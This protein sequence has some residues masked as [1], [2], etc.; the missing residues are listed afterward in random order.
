VLQ[1]IELHS[2]SL[3][4]PAEI[5]T[6]IYLRCGSVVEHEADDGAAPRRVCRPTTCCCCLFSLNRALHHANCF[7]NKNVSQMSLGR[8]S[9]RIWSHICCTL[10]SLFYVRN[11]TGGT[12]SPSQCQVALKE[13]IRKADKIWSSWPDT[14]RI[15]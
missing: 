1:G 10:I 6:L 12:A 14:V 2:Q 3:S 4:N 11:R 5:A 13:D 8:P 7:H 9:Q 15:V